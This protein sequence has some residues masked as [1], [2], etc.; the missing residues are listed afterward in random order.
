MA[1][2]EVKNP[3]TN[4]GDAVSI[5]G[6]GRA[7]REGN[8]SLPVFLPGKSQGQ[9][10]LAGSSQRGLREPDTAGHTHGGDYFRL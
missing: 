10:S 3:P 1:V 6:L 2:L 7:L 4:A 5:S 9:R 8:G